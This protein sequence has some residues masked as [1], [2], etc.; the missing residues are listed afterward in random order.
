MKKS[1]IDIANQIFRSRSLNVMFEENEAEIM[2][3]IMVYIENSL[4]MESRSILVQN[5]QRLESFETVDENLSVGQEFGYLERYVYLKLQK[6]N[7]DEVNDILSIP[8]C[9][10]SESLMHISS[11]MPVRNLRVEPQ[12]IRVKGKANTSP[13][14]KNNR[15]AEKSNCSCGI[16]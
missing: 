15:Y 10:L 11:T 2:K 12:V 9:T 16:V 8:D 7:V 6:K 3:I 14:P 1:I 13:N 4:T 5:D